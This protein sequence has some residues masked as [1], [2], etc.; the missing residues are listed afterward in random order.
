MKIRCLGKQLQGE[1]K[2]EKK[3]WRWNILKQEI[4]GKTLVFE[5]SLQT[6]HN[7]VVSVTDDCKGN[8]GKPIRSQCK[9]CDWNAFQHTLTCRAWQDSIQWEFFLYIYFWSS[10]WTSSILRCWYMWHA[11]IL[12][13]LCYVIFD[14]TKSQLS[15]YTIFSWNT[16]NILGALLHVTC[17]YNNKL[18][19][20]NE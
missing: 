18:W 9:Y 3:R 12:T 19:M 7:P 17:T 16:V 2:E 11:W 6:V 4:W 5:H 14:K 15:N 1:K 10:D 13:V 20:N 8:F